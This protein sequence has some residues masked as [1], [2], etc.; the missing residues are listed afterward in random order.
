MSRKTILAFA[1]VAALG[2]SALTPNSVSA[3]GRHGGFHA[4]HTRI[5]GPSHRPYRAAVG[6]TR[7]SIYAKRKIGMGISPDG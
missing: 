5:S 1:A 4:A 6:R 7:T 2:V 3:S